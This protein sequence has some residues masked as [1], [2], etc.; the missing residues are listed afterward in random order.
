MGSK[1]QRA[2]CA[3]TGRRRHLVANAPWPEAQGS[4]G[5]LQ[6]LGASDISSAV[7]QAR[8]ECP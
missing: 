7:T 1:L 6:T 3:A 2:R 8:M 4:P 5:C